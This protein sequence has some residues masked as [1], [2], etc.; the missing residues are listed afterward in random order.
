MKV[1]LLATLRDITDCKEVCLEA[2][3]I[4][5]VIDE[6]IAEYGSA[7]ENKLLDDK[8]VRE[9]LTILVNGRNILY[10]DG[11]ETELKTKDV[12]TIFPRVAGG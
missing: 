2:S 6:L 4:N 9:S 10:L 12:V 3:N 5:Q 11:L 8:E 1:K 7:M